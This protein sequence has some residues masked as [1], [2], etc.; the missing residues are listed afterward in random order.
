MV[1]VNREEWPSSTRGDLGWE[2]PRHRLMPTEDSTTSCPLTAAHWHRSY[3]ELLDLA[4]MHL[5][6][7]DAAWYRSR[8]IFWSERGRLLRKP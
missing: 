7:E 8:M 5:L 6:T 4:E 1:L 3:S 2:E